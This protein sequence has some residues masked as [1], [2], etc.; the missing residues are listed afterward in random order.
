MYINGV[1]DKMAG[2]DIVRKMMAWLLQNQVNW[3]ERTIKFML[4]SKGQSENT[5]KA[6]D[7]VATTT[8]EHFSW[9][10]QGHLN[11][12]LVDHMMT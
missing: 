3:Q 9:T 8:E 2:E 4:K 1:H 11:L 7:S 12:H 10:L 5:K 6:T